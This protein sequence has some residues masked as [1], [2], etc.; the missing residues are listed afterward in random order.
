MILL[1]SSRRPECRVP[2]TASLHNSKQVDQ[3]RERTMEVRKG[4]SKRREGNEVNEV[5]EVYDEFRVAMT[6][7]KTR[8]SQNPAFLNNTP[9]TVI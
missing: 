3:I 7:P 9:G 5:G 1:L 6:F 4:E 8:I 2:T